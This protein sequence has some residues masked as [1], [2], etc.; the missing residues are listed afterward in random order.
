M[1]FDI[2]EFKKRLE[3]ERLQGNA[4]A[5]VIQQE[6][7]QAEE[8]KAGLSE[9]NDHASEFVSE[10]IN[11][12]DTY[13]FQLHELAKDFNPADFELDQQT[14]LQDDRMHDRISDRIDRLKEQGEANASTEDPLLREGEAEQD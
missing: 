4:A 1:D 10:A 6:V 13:I 11:R 7:R 5:P 14:Y 2:P 3:N 8:V 12:I 9:E